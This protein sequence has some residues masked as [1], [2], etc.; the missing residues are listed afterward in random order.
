MIFVEV[1]IGT[2]LEFE[3]ETLLVCFEIT[4]I[5]SWTY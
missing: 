2:W 5:V 4:N 1:L 3:I